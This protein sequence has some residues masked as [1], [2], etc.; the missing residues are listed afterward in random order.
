M[1]YSGKPQNV[2]ED[3]S[4][5]HR[6]EGIYTSHPLFRLPAYSFPSDLLPIHFKDIKAKLKET[7]A[8]MHKT[9]I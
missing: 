3:P 7:Q 2:I 6:G 5:T 4:S 1:S 9:V 8:K